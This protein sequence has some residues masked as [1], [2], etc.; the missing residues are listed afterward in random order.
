MTE[1]TEIWLP[2]VGH[3]GQ[4]EVSSLGR[5]RSLDRQVRH[6]GK[7]GYHYRLKKGR[8]LSQNL[9]NS[10]YLVVHLYTDGHRQVGLVHR[11]V[12]LAFLGEGGDLEVDHRDFNKQNN[13]IGNLRWLTHQVN[14]ARSAPNRLT[15]TARAVIGE[16]ADGTALAFPSQMVAEKALLGRITGIVSWAIKKGR[17]AIGCNWSRVC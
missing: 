12:A 6:L 9:I 8:V 2:V 13:T 15:S 4:Y 11:L 7:Y 1:R 5:V 10:G 3:E 17:P 16:F 14:S